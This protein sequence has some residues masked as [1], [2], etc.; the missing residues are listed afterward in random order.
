MISQL[1][2]KL[3]LRVDK[4]AACHPLATEGAVPLRIGIVR[5]INGRR[6]LLV[7]LSVRLF[8]RFVACIAGLPMHRLG[9]FPDE[10]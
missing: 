4:A 6:E 9:I 10:R 1:Q 2:L 7:P 8:A 5:R 3:M